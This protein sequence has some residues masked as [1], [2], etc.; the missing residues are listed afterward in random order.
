[1]LSSCANDCASVSESLARGLGNE[2]P[3][4]GSQVNYTL[5]FSFFDEISNCA[6]LISH[7]FACSLELRNGQL[8]YSTKRSHRSR[9]FSESAFNF[10]RPDSHLHDTVVKS[11]SGFCSIRG[12]D[13]RVETDSNPISNMSINY[14]LRP[15]NGFAKV[16]LD[17]SH[18]YLVN[19]HTVPTSQVVGLSEA[20]FLAIRELLITNQFDNFQVHH[21]FHAQLEG[22]A[23]A[24]HV[25]NF[26][27][28]LTDNFAAA[29][30]N[31]VTY[32]LGQDGP[33][34]QSSIMLDMSD[35]ISE[36]LHSRM[37]ATY[38]GARI[39][40]ENLA[41]AATDHFR[42]LLSSVNLETGE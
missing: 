8:D 32:Y 42:R 24:D 1:M 13:I 16:N 41:E 19:P 22:M 29:V 9:F 7:P 25:R 5:I 35:E 3:L 27:V 18:V 15:F 6:F 14:D 20:F 4:P 30:G 23:P 17:G 21:S 40:V 28:P 2:S 31:A 10:F 36:C 34:T 39:S 33:R 26:V 37:S 38:D 11:L 12:N